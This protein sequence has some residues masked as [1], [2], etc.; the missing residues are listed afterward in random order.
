MADNTQRPIV[1]TRIRKK[2]ARHHSGPWKIAYA[3]FIPAL[4]A[5]FPLLC[6]RGT[7][8][9]VRDEEGRPLFDLGR[10]RLKPYARDILLALSKPLNEVENRLSLTGQTDATPYVSGERAYSNWELSADRA[11]AARR[12][13]VTGGI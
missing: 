6:R 10:A 8:H 5:F 13:L 3:A 11:N 12:V 4:L 7:P 2:A 1:V 9:T